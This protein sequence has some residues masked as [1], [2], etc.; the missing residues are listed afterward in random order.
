ML[1]RD[2]FGV[3]KLFLV[4]RIR[5]IYIESIHIQRFALVFGKRRANC[6]QLLE[7]GY[8]YICCGKEKTESEVVIFGCLTTSVDIR[9]KCL[10]GF[11]CLE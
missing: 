8:I 3:I 10:E 9:P 5:I 6:N 11:G 4:D 7:D 1:Y 2:A